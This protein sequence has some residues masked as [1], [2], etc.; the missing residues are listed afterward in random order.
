M[1]ALFAGTVQQEIP[2]LTA[3]E[4]AS[5]YDQYPHLLVAHEAIRAYE[6]FQ[7]RMGEKELT[8][9]E[10]AKHDRNNRDAI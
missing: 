9:D 1:Q 10:Q 6:L 4:I 5:Y 3:M 8:A 7:Q 2:L